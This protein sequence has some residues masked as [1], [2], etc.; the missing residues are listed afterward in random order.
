M[1]IRAHL[2]HGD[3]DGAFHGRR[4]RFYNLMAT[5]L[6]RRVYRR[7]AQDIA[8]L[9]PKDGALLDIGTG[10]GV[11]LA[12]LAQL[13]PDLTL[14]GIDLSDDMVT[15][16]RRNLAPYGDRATVQVGDASRLPVAD[17]SFDLVVSSFSLHHWEDPQA[18]V[19]ELARVLRPG[20]RVCIY[21]FRFAP[22]D[23]LTATA[24]ARSVLTA[25]PPQQT[26]VRIATF[27]PR[28][29]RYTMSAE[30]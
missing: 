15:A 7:L 2:L 11:L 25:Q 6:L 28:C 10:P 27:L 23:Q 9:A 1:R 18:A 4:S 17:R 20:G 19:P 26:L 5:R 3:R 21:D 16:A 29:I 24:Q 8:E 12:E 13:R 22:F 30:T 14:T